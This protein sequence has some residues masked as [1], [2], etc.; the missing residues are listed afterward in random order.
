[1]EMKT[2]YI[3]SPKRSCKRRDFAELTVE[4]ARNASSSLAPG[5]M[6]R[7]TTILTTPNIKTQDRPTVIAR[8]IHA[9]W[10]FS[11][12][13]ANG[14]CCP[15][16]IIKPELEF[17][18]DMIKAQKM[19]ELRTSTEMNC[20]RGRG[21]ATLSGYSLRIFDGFSQSPTGKPDDE[22]SSS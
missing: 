17:E 14:A 18:L 12:T 1:M 13:T 19:D 2:L 5:L 10:S 9:V 6:V 22:G 16:G 11:L 8:I 21:K 3:K 7:R 4:A 20:V 15:G